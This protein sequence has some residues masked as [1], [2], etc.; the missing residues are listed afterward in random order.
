MPTP[1]ASCAGA[2]KRWTAQRVEFLEQASKDESLSADE[3]LKYLVELQAIRR[4]I[5]GNRG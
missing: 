1:K 2:E 3:R 5:A 4:R